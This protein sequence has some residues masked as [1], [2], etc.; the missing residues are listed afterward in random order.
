M[1]NPR[2]VF[3]LLL[4][5]VVQ[6][7]CPACFVPGAFGSPSNEEH[8]IGVQ[9]PNVLMIVLDDQNDWVSPLEGHPQV[10]TPYLRTL[11]DRGVIF[12]NAHCQAPL[13]NP[14]RTSVL[15]G[16]RPTTTG[17]YGLEPWFRES[18]SLS[19]LVSLPQYFGQNGYQTYSTGKVFHGEQARNSQPAEFDFWGPVVTSKIKPGKK[20]IPP[21]ENGNHPLMD[22][23]E[24]SGR[25]EDQ[26]DFQ[27]AS[28]AVEKLGKMP[29]DQP[30]FLAVGFT[31]PHVPCMT[32][33]RWLDLY[34]ERGLSLAPHLPNDRDDIPEFAWNLHWSVPEPRRSWL[35]KHGQLTSLTRSYLASTSF[36]DGQIG[37]VIRAL[38]DSAHAD[39][40]I[41][42]LWSD[43]GWHLGEKAIT[44]KNSLWELATRVPLIFSGP[45]IRRGGECELP[46]ELLDIF[47]TLVELCGL[48]GKAGLEGESLKP[49]LENARA[50]RQRPAITTHNPGNHAVR[51]EDWRYIVYADR[52][53]ELYDMQSDPNEHYNLARNSNYRSQIETMRSSVPQT[54][55]PH[56]PGSAG[57]VLWKKGEEWLW[58]GKPIVPRE[59][60]R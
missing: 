28:W 9:R 13:C 47:P 52:S 16:L 21:T 43:N 38:K 15:T 30:F 58:E 54:N 7:G 23:G 14:S 46:V 39:N 40:T 32:T 24:F 19:K 56:A 37:R 10:Q 44:G 53:E 1:T 59:A 8:L 57:R 50:T 55:A 35:E 25:D 29:V 4:V 60:Q 33:K 5:L 48:P 51:F 6:F 27:I 18:E 31:S 12:L 34:P 20:Q 26:V 36:V 17:I 41:I 49:L 45:G 42:V 11:Q 2:F 3:F 22:W